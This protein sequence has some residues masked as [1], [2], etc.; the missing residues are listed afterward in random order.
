MKS[1]RSTKEVQRLTGMVAALNR[2]VA[3]ATDKC[4]PFFQAIKKGKD[5][6]WEEKCE[7]AFNDL[8]A[9]LGKPPLLT[10]P[11][12]S[13]EL[14]LYLA[15][16]EHVVSA[17]LIREEEKV[18]WPIYYVSKALLDAETHYPEMEKVLQIMTSRKL[19]PYFQ[20]HPIIVLTS[21]PLRQV[22]QK[23]DMSGRLAKWSIELGEFEVKYKPR[24]AIKGQALAH[25]VAEFSYPV[26]VEDEEVTIS[27]PQR[28]VLEDPQS[29]QASILK[30][31]FGPVWQLYVDGASNVNGCGTGLILISPKNDRIRYALRF[32][33]KVSNNEAEYEAL[34]AGL[35]LAQELQ[36]EN[37]KIY[38]DSQ[39]IVN[40]VREEFQAKGENMALY[41]Q[42]VKDQLEKFKWHELEQVPRAAN[43]E[44]DCLARMAS[45][46]D[47]D[48]LGNVPIKVLEQSSIAKHVEVCALSPKD[49]SSW[50]TPIFLYLSTGELPTEKNE[51]RRLRCLNKDEANYVMREI[52]EGICGNHSG[53]R[54]LSYKALRQ[55]YY[56]P[57]MLKDAMELVKVCDKCQ[58]FSHIPRQPGEPLTSISSPWP[59][60]MWGID[61]IGPLPLANGRYKYAIVA[62][63]YFTKWVEAQELP[64]ITEA[65]VTNFIW[66]SI[67]CR[68]GIPHSIITDNARQFDNE[69]LK[70]ICRQMGIQKSFSSP[71]H[72]QANGLVEVVNKT[73][74]ENLTY[75][76]ETPFSMAYGVES[77]IPA[78]V[79]MPTYRVE[80]YDKDQNNEELCTDLDLVEEKREQATIRAAVYQQATARYY[81]TRVK[82]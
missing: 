74:K 82:E 21:H 33:F 12:L 64:R 32:A 27:V 6:V 62:I 31:P 37:L 67:I 79:G 45:G 75:T 39:L 46:M 41:L 48:Q 72:P 7:K 15:V 69:E 1:P 66:K 38:S 10:K 63:D 4:Q 2:F 71:E 35:R 24:T 19:R 81:N 70:S 52:H 34:L 53:G 14:Y 40:Q 36:I 65:N 26:V 51:A 17:V 55:G 42:K 80:A 77:V 54:S 11:K 25:F 30:K 8:K 59:F 58:H 56:W 28:K 61:I 73:I 68:F 49:A 3:R 16:S 18:Q 50:I 9:Y 13:E 47:E 5:F 57:T 78:E 44:A 60:A 76:G 29:S 22:L 20:S 43:M 23:P